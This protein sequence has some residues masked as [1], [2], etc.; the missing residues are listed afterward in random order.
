MNAIS[1]TTPISYSYFDVF[2]IAGELLLGKLEELAPKYARGKLIDLGCGTKPYAAIF[3][4]YVDSY[5]GVDF[6]DTADAHYGASTRADLY[7]DCTDTG[8]AAGSF[9]TLLST[10]VMEHI[11]ETGKYIAECNRLLRAG[12]IGIFTIPF[13]CEC[14]AE[15][16]DYYRFTRYSIQRLFEEHG[17]SVLELSPLGGA[18]ATLIQIKIMSIYCREPRNLPHRIFRKVRNTI[19]IPILNFMALHLDKYFWND[20][21]CINY[22]VVVKKK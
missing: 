12:G 6:K 10:Q 2:K 4:K 22:S 19:F 3:S 13:V 5:F 21:L 18:Y 8:L 7:A 15:P 17:F 14:H 1:E 20:K 11:Y 9:D 16:H